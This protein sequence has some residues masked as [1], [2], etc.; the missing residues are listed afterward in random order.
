[1]AEKIELDDIGWIELT[2]RGA[3]DAATGERPAATRVLDVYQVHD[4]WVG[5]HKEHKDKS[6]EEYNAAL[7]TWVTGWGFPQ[8]SQAVAINFLRLIR[9]KTKAI[10]DFFS[11]M[12]AWSSSTASPP[13]AEQSSPSASAAA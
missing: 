6:A 7:A 12:P 9:V 3:P 5:F 2:V 11:Q 13:G 8:C 1:M 4:A 10:Q